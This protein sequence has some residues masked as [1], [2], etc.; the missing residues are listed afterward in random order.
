MER[1]EVISARLLFHFVN[2]PI[3]I[4]AM[5]ANC[6]TSVSLGCISCY[7]CCDMERIRNASA[8]LPPP[9]SYTVDDS[10]EA[11]SARP[12][13][14]I[15]YAMDELRSIQI[16]RAAAE[17][18]KV[19]FVDTRR[20]H[21][22][23]LVWLHLD[24][25]ASFGQ[26]TGTV[27][28]HLPMNSPL[29]MLHCHGNA[30]DIGLMMASY[31]D[32]VKRL[33]VDVVGVEYAGYGFSTGSPSTTNAL[34]DVEA[35]YDH[36][37]EM[38]VNPTRIVAYGQSVGSGPVCSLGSKRKLGGIV[39]HSPMLSGIKVL[40]AD[41]DGCCRPSCV[42]HLCDFYP[43]DSSVKKVS[44]PVFVMHGKRDSVVRF[45]HGTRMCNATPDKYR[46]PGYF[47]A[48]AGHND[49]LECNVKA[50]FSKLHSFL[51]F[52][53]RRRP[54]E[55]VPKQVPLQVE[56]VGRC[57]MPPSPREPMADP[58]KWSHSA[59]SCLAGRAR[60]SANQIFGVT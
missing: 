29:V 36:L 23:P 4:G 19:S 16:Y 8:F 30:T 45:H 1:V 34:S 37:I 38:G 24:T 13:A 25:L 18:A 57:D 10:Q 56:M 43:N 5:G 50:Y 40:D 58:Q 9:P 46:W 33:R 15:V 41:P 11:G 26:I 17:A 32:F 27:G 12:A 20:G 22:I 6:L 51:E 2:V 49:I 60:E 52:V 54:G 39:L 7:H 31:L 28:A 35:A 53:K 48:G 55:P 3:V 14:K 42:Y 47:P 44:C 59:D 21:R